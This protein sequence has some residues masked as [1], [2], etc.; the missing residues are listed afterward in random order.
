MKVKKQYIKR[1]FTALLL[2]LPLGIW[3]QSKN[4]SILRFATQQI[5]ENPD[6]T[7][8]IAKDLFN[9][10]DATADDKVR[11]VLLISTAYSS[12]RE[13]EK[14][15][16]YALS[17]IDLLPQLKNENQ[18]INLL[19]RIGG[20]YQELQLYEK[21]ILYLDK[22]VEFI[23]KLPEG[24]EK[25][26]FLGVNNL[27]RGFVYRE[28]MSCDIALNYFEKGIEDYKKFPN[29]VGGNANISISY[30]NRGNC[31]IKLGRIKEAEIDFLQSIE[32]AQK[33]GATSA[34]AFA[35]KGLAE[36][37]TIQ[38]Q[39]SKA[40]NLLNEALQNSEGVGD[41][42][43]NRSIYEALATN[44]LA[45]SDYG[46]YFLFRNKNIAI[47][48]QIKKAER[49]TVDDSIRDLLNVNS[50]KIE[51]IENRTKILQIVLSILILLSLIFIIRQVILSEK[52]LKS[53][54]KRLK[55]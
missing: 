16:E 44:Y 31:L 45:T 54:K 8:R 42:V 11:A 33:A 28:Q 4:D 32:F 15:M 7:I 12:K 36:V 21:A 13:Y 40:I 5:Y 2:L 27:L 49:K 20:L 19:N 43:L 53:L 38:N 14:A 34:I 3:A 35:M 55:F 18:K 52:S 10:T 37:Y 46:N 50:K 25:S 47:H 9:E 39:Y 17:G 26:R 23:D 41:K 6:T 1:V 24:E 22:A 29:T 48:K 51:T 30:Y